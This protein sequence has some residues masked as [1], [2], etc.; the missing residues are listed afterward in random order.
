MDGFCLDEFRVIW[1]TDFILHTQCIQ[2]IHLVFDGVLLFCMDFL[3]YINLGI[4]NKRLC[5]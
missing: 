5:A 3:F 1:K 2:A 4:S